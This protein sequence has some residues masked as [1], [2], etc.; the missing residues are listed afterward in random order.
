MGASMFVHVF[1]AYFG[2]TVSLVLK[3]D[4]TSEKEGAVYNSDIFA[5]I[6]NQSMDSVDKFSLY[7][8]IWDLFF[9]LF[10]T[11]TI[12]LWLFWPS[13][14]AGL[15]EGD[16]Q[17]RAVINTYYSLAACCVMAFAIS[18]LV[19]K[20]NKFDMVTRFFFFNFIFLS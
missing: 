6:G 1:G 9:I 20:E 3:R 12:F 19:S 5:M 7:S 16:A 10:S 8:Y 2:L 15:A 13:F 14:N 17:H 11:G 18:S 4:L